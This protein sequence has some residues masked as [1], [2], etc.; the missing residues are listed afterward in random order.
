MSSEPDIPLS[1]A[2][3]WQRYNTQLSKLLAKGCPIDITPEI[4]KDLLETSFMTGA[5]A[6]LSILSRAS[7]LGASPEE[8]GAILSRMIEE[9]DRS[10]SAMMQRVLRRLIDNLEKGSAE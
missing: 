5:S 4:Q 1:L 6:A 2:A 3:C 8:G 10:D 7:K 9:I